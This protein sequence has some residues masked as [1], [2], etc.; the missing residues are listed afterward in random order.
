MKVEAGKFSVHTE[1][2]DHLLVESEL[3]V[4]TR[5]RS[6]YVTSKISLKFWKS[7]MGF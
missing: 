7:G 3:E 4:T 6:S 2:K 5:E 1:I